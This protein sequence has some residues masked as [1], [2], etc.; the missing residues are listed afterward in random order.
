MLYLSSLMFAVAA[1]GLVCSAQPLEARTE[2]Q[3]NIYAY[4]T[5]ISGLRVFYADGERIFLPT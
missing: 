5:G 3:F 2:T 1:F 4:G